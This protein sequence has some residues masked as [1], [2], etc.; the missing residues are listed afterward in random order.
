[1]NNDLKKIKAVLETLYNKYN[2]FENI[3]PDPLQFAYS[4]NEKNDREIAAFIAGIFAYG[5]VFQIEKNVSWVLSK[6][7]DS[8]FKF[9]KDYDES[10]DNIFSD[11][12]YRFNKP[13]DVTDLFKLL[14]TVFLEYASLEEYFLEFYD[15]R[16][17]DTVPALIC[18]IDGL[19]ARHKQLN[20]G[21]INKGLGYLLP[22]PR[23]KSA[24][25]RLNLFLK[26]MVRDD[27]VDT[28]LWKSVSPAKLLIPVDTHIARLC[29]F[30]GL[31][32]QKTVSLKTAIEITENFAKIEPG[33]PAKYDFAL[34]RIGI[35][36][37]CTGKPN[38][39]CKDCE[40]YGFCVK[41]REF[42]T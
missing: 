2:H 34:S 22:N 11:F 21:T 16:Q 10:K 6:M 37:N 23:N 14:K 36:E 30:L 17:K 26:W 13:E 20:G 31:Y 24:C 1:M 15:P 4:Y 28:G 25:K 7:G 32:R 42:K 29:K 12:K 9:V 35:V 39:Y 33:D 8:P 18:F 3:K 41:K 40:L 19:T 5:N 38:D 27:E